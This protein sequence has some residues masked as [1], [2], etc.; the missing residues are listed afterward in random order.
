MVAGGGLSL[1]LGEQ[2]DV[3]FF[4]EVLYR[5]GKG[6]FPVPLAGPADSAG[7]PPG[8]RARSGG[9]AALHL[10]RLREQAELVAPDDHGRAILRGSQTL[11]AA[12]R[13]DGPRAGAASR[14]R[15]AGGRAAAGQGPRDCVPDHGIPGLE[16]LG[17]EPELR[18]CPVES[19][20]LLDRS[21][22]R[23]PIDARRL[24]AGAKPRSGAL[25]A[26]RSV[27]FASGGRRAGHDDYGFAL[28][29][30][31]PDGGLLGY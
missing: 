7:R 20:C 28:G 9:P 31:R 17:I 30:R 21:G 22:R 13:F 16:R 25:P 18:A 6:L 19:S 23:K 26:C 11:G 24:A 29:R 10:S 4:N 14:R 8:T 15:A 1:F 3:K 12:R 5:R 27:H 2:T